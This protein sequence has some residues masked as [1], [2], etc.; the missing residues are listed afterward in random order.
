MVRTPLVLALW[1][2]MVTVGTA[3]D[4]PL[5]SVGDQKYLTENPSGGKITHIKYPTLGCASILK[6]GDS[7]TASIW[8]NDAGA[9]SLFELSLV[10]TIGV[11]SIVYDLPVT[12]ISYD[13]ATSLY[14][15]NYVVPT[16]VPADMYDFQASIPSQSI[17]DI[18]YNSVRIV[19]EETGTYTFI[20]VADP[21]FN[22]PRGLM[23]PA[24]YSTGNYDAYSIVN[25]MKKEIRALNPTFVIMLG[26]VTFGLDYEYEYQGAWE[27]WK[28]AG[29]AIFMAPGNHDGMAT[30][31]DR[32]FL[33]FGS[34]KRD[35]LEDWRKYFGPNYYSFEF[36]GIHLQAVNSFD[37]T[38][39]RRDS[40]LI[41][42]E[43]HGGD[44]S[45][46]QMDWIAADMATAQG[47]VVPFMHHSPLGPYRE[48]GTF[49]MFTWILERI[50]EFITTGSFD[51]YSQTWNS[52]STADWMLS[53]YSVL[54]TVFIGHNHSDSIKQY[55]NTQY[56]MVTTAGSSGEYWGYTVVQ[57]VNQDI[58][59]TIYMNQDFMS[60]P[61]G[62]LHVVYLEADPHKP[63]VREAE[64]RSGLSRSYPVI[65]EFEMPAASSYVASNGT[66]ISH[67]PLSP[68]Y[69]RVLVEADTPVA[70]DIYNPLRLVVRVETAQ[71]LGSVQSTGANSSSGNGGGGCGAPLS[72]GHAQGHFLLLALPVFFLGLLRRSGR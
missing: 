5:V 2:S 37:G 66:V 30:I 53:Q 33:G 18:Q 72:P 8:L 65:L 70:S 47:T 35:G 59:D 24:N 55:N 44:L 26:D 7:G 31:E 62:N 21:Q 3:S 56:R 51:D 13:S 60:I 42:N 28:D 41:V 49:G 69:S 46:E 25:Q 68:G 52:Q 15:V 16:G 23:D 38:P 64:V 67:D 29:F 19:S 6:P 71:V 10:P 34:P 22:D 50:W 27:M 48:N 12:G 61:T 9:S 57:V 43:N 17:M 1:V 11:S 4:D 54:P 39:E 20:V 32:T 58:V 40:F 14:K 45:V 63:E 36:G